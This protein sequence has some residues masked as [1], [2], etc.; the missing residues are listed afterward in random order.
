MADCKRI[1]GWLK[2]G[3]LSDPE[4][5]KC[6]SE[7]INAGKLLKSIDIYCGIANIEQRENRNGY[8]IILQLTWVYSVIPLFPGSSRVNTLTAKIVYISVMPLFPGSSR[9]NS[10]TA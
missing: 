10:L 5:L 7:L 4:G 2:V 3:N 9:V 6:A 1:Q 8:F